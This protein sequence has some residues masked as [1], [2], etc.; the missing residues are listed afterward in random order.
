M[1]DE[2]YHNGVWYTRT[3]VPIGEETLAVYELGNVSGAVTVD[4]TNGLFQ[5]LT[6]TG[7]VTLTLTGGVTGS[8]K[9]LTLEITNGGSA[10]FNWP[11]EVEFNGGGV[12]P[13]LTVAGKDIVQLYARG[14]S[15]WVAGVLPNVS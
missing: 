2:I 14:T 1:S 9:P 4:L 10:T 11:A 13:T 3:G 8:A 7:V 12:A 15:A 5:T 6:V